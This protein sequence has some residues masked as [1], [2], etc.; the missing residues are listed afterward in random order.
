M[1]YRR[2][3]RIVI[4]IF[5]DK[6]SLIKT[7][8]STKH[9]ASSVRRVV[10]RATSHGAPV[11]TSDNR[12]AAV[13]SLG[14]GSRATASV[15]IQALMDRLHGTKNA[16][17]AL[18]CLYTVHNAI[19]KGSFILKDQL[20]VY[21]SSGGR[22]FLNMSRFRD[23]SDH[24]NWEISSWVRWYAGV[25]EQNLMVSRLL[26]HHLCSPPG[27]KD[28]KRGKVSVLS[29]LDILNDVDVLVGFVEQIGNVPESLH[30]RRNSL[31]FEA[32]RLVREDYRSVQR[33]IW[34][35]VGE[36]GE[37]MV[38]L[39][40]GE[41][42]RFLGCLKRTEDCKE[43]LSSLFGNRKMN[44]ELWELIRDTKINL[45][46]MMEE[47]RKGKVPAIT[48]DNSGE[49]TRFGRLLR[50]ASGGGWLSTNRMPLTVS[51]IR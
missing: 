7:T 46:E 47:K 41:L 19:A 32:V 30:L 16:T 33:E 2:K 21:P 23:D 10:I 49:L 8:L 35:R 40:G 51:T 11:V 50:S 12:I 5:K 45:E 38:S 13:L 48:E 18:K 42:I 17:V 14:Q 25:L 34:I 6:A 24:E 29:N 39:S 15:C 28:D 36:L 1:G 37:R 20:S 43:K 26:G 3:L 4:G 9:H 44:E 31:V 22:N 27:A